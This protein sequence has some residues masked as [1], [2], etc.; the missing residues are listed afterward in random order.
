MDCFSP[1]FSLIEA[2]EGDVDGKQRAALQ[3]EINK[4]SESLRKKI[5]KGL[6]KSEFAKAE[7][8]LGAC[9]TA[10][11]CVEKIWAQMHK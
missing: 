11:L 1:D 8:L 2:L 9:E 4:M 6:T 5:D 7:L 10:Y 3:Q